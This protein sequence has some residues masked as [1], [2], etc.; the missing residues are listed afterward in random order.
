MTTRDMTWAQYHAAAK[1][2]GFKPVLFWL[3][4]ISGQ[5]GVSYRTVIDAKTGKM[6]RRASIAHCIAK[7]DRDVTRGLSDTRAKGE[8]L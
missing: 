7:R 5:T 2:N 6:N 4:D 1:R 3:E 8:T